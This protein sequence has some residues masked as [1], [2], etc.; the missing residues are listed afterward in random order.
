MSVSLRGRLN[1][2]GIA[3]RRDGPLPSVIPMQQ[4]PASLRGRRMP[5]ADQRRST[6]LD[7]ALNQNWPAVRQ[8]ILELIARPPQKCPHCRK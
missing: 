7:E 2:C 6:L 4:I 3:K 1:Y 5:A 8:A